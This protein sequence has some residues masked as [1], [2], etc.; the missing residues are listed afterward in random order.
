MTAVPILI[1]GRKRIVG[2]FSN[3]QGKFS[4]PEYHRIALTYQPNPHGSSDVFSVTGGPFLASSL[5]KTALATNKD[6]Q[7]YFEAQLMRM[8]TCLGTNTLPVFVN[9]G[10]RRRMDK[11]CV[12]HSVARGFLEPVQDS[13]RGYVEYV[14]IR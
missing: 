12:G 5:G 7:A 9:W 6:R 3:D 14:Q 1:S 8:R 4:M 2:S 10:G 13:A 11:G